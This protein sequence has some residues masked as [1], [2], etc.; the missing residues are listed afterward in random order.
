MFS[1]EEILELAI[2]IEMNAEQVYH[3]AL[4]KTSNSSLALLL[5]WL[6][7]EEARHV[8]WFSALKKTIKKT[9]SDPKIAEMGQTLLRETLGEMSFSLK[10]ANFSGVQ[11]TKELLSLT[12]EFERDK[13]QFFT[14]LRA[15][16]DEQETL[17]NLDKI[18]DEENRHVQHLQQF[19]DSDIEMV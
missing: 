10:D 14:M 4:K 7:D 12:A 11:E 6:I 15:F 1:S 9:D 13:V 19:I 5:S 17:D 18:I 3:D 16:I 2:Q 8:E